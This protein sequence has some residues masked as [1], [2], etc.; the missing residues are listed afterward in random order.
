[1]KCPKCP[2]AIE[3]HWEFG[4]TKCRCGHRPDCTCRGCD[5]ARKA[6]EAA[7]ALRDLTAWL[8]AV[9]YDASPAE[10]T[11][12]QAAEMARGYVAEMLARWPVARVFR[13][14]PLPVVDPALRER[15]AALAAE[16]EEAAAVAGNI[17]LRALAERIRSL[18]AT[19]AQTETKGGAK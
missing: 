13:G 12:E 4:C 3:E 5:K 11:T 19:P 14:T 9:V 6:A 8:S 7:E 17:T 15:L 18:L 10:V 1:M 16:T 2:H